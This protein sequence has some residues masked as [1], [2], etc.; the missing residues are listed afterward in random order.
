MA[1]R[2]V[3][4]NARPG[5]GTNFS[6]T[7]ES[8]LATWNHRS[9]DV[10]KRGGRIGEEH[11]PHPGE[12]YVKARNREIVSLDVGE[13]ELDSQFRLGRCLFATQNE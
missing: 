11:D 12:R 9:M 13:L 8:E 10:G 5:V 6:P 4:G 2:N 1:A 3:E 7:N